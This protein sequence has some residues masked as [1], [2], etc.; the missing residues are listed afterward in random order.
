MRDAWDDEEN[1]VEPEEPDAKELWEK[2][3]VNEL[4]LLYCFVTNN[5]ILQ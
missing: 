3:Y 2:A 1:D 4:M 5:S